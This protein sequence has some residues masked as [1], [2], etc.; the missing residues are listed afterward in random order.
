MRVPASPKTNLFIAFMHAYLQKTRIKNCLVSLF[1]WS[2]W[3]NGD[4]MPCFFLVLCIKAFFIIFFPVE[5]FMSN[6]AVW[7]SPSGQYLVYATFNDTRVGEA[8]YTWYADDLP[9]PKLR[10]LKYP[11]VGTILVGISPTRECKNENGYRF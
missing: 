9:Y 11:K 8:S 2:K 7:T 6:N 10:T 3:N 1:E 4:F 5:I